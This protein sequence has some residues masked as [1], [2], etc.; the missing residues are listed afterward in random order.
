MT[1]SG[2]DTSAA[3]ESASAVRSDK[4]KVDEAKSDAVS[5]CNSVGKGGVLSAANSTIAH[6]DTTLES[7]SKL[8]EAKAE[9]M[10]YAAMGLWGP[11][12]AA[13]A[14][15]ETA[16][17]SLGIELDRARSDPDLAKLA[18]LLPETMNF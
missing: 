5:A 16:A 17:Q 1:M 18:G 15:A 11:H 10:E 3:R 14:A 4:T 12:S 7:L 2:I 9:A 6:L 8:I 13:N